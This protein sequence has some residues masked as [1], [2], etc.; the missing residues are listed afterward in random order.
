MSNHSE[1]IQALL[2]CGSADIDFI[3]NE[4]AKFKVDA[5][6]VVEEAERYGCSRITA[7]DLIY[8][9]YKLA[10][11][12]AGCE[13]EVEIYSDSDNVSIF[14]NCIDS[15]LWVKSKDGE[16]V[17]MHDY[18]ELVEFLKANYPKSEEV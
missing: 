17:E 11:I 8:A 15:H 5:L 6:E 16:S 14:T 13:C 4:L 12:E 2:D 18:D 9:I 10:I 7:N 1:I 3:D